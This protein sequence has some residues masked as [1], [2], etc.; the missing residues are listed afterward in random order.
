[1]PAHT[2][3]P[4]LT[5]SISGKYR[6][7][8]RGREGGEESR[9]AAKLLSLLARLSRRVCPACRREGGEDEGM[10]DWDQ[11]ML[12]KAIARAPC[13]VCLLA[14]CCRKGRR[15]RRRWRK[16][17]T[18]FGTPGGWAGAQI[19]VHASI[20]VPP[21]AAEIREA[22][23]RTATAPPNHLL[24][25]CSSVLLKLRAAPHPL[26]SFPQQRSTPPTTA[27]APPRSS[28]S[29]SLRRWRRSSTAG[30]GT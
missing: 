13:C 25:A 7:S 27:T 18:L 14:S 2:V 3:A 10:D 28:A 12:E 19:R 22:P 1:M 20:P 24:P 30:S 8:G 21:R 11:E 5:G 4:Q 17:T 26:R 29:S 15:C 9:C 23:R 6:C 16:R